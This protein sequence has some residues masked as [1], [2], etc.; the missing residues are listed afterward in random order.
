M[1]STQYNISIENQNFSVFKLFPDDLSLTNSAKLK[2]VIDNQIKSGIKN[3]GIDLSDVVAVNSSGLGI[4]IGLLNKVKSE[5]GNFKLINPKERL[6]DVFK[7]TKLN[8]VFEVYF[9]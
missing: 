6:I 9:S 4:L 3:I 2:D 1:E 5:N 8:L 7:I